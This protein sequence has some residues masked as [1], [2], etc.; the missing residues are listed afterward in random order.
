MELRVLRALRGSNPLF[1][2]GPPFSIN[3]RSSMAVSPEAARV[4]NPKSQDKNQA[5]PLLRLTFRLLASVALTACFAC[6]SEKPSRNDARAAA[7]PVAQPARDSATIKVADGCPADGR[8]APCSVEKRLRRSGFVVKKIEGA[9]PDRPGFSVKP[10]IYNLGRGRL[11][12]FLY[13][14]EEALA[15]D[16]AALDSVSA[17]P[18]GQ[19]GKWPSSPGFVRSANLA[20]VFMDQ[21]AR[22]AE[23]LVLAI[24]A[25]PPSAR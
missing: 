13:E 11:E 6:E 22:Q 5:D 3:R 18:R 7:V 10:L 21:T 9:P 14:N 17:A 24:T 16:L 25:G 23:R 12:V 19:P 8:W 4:L 2:F 1:R 15:N 20:A